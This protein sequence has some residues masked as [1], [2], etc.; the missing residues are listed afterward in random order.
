AMAFWGPPFVESEAQARLA[1]EA[2]LLQIERFARFRAELPDLLGV[3]SYR[4]ALGLRIG[5][6][7]GDVIAGSVGSQEAMNYTVLGDPVNIAARLEKLNKRYGTSIL[8]SDG[9]AAMLAGAAVL[10]EVDKVAVSGRDGS[11]AIFELIAMQGE[12]DAARDALLAAYAAALAAYRE[13]DW[14][15]AAAGFRACLDLAPQ[16]GPSRTMLARCER[17]QAQ[18]PPDDW[19]GTWRAADG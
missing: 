8:V 18:P 14:T 6:A 16:D 12:A 10:R 17:L 13:R 5:I 1:C 15:A 11:L 3:K 9:T 2:A 4:P 7:T 19:D